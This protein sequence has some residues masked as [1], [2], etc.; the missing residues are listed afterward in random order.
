MVSPSQIISARESSVGGA[1]PN[2]DEIHRLT[3]SFLHFF[4]FNSLADL[5]PLVP[6][7]SIWSSMNWAKIMEGVTTGVTAAT[8]LALFALMRYRVGDLIFRWRLRHDLKNSALA[9][10]DTA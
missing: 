1:S 10:I 2:F 7:R 4:F 8:V 6:A 9:G 5:A 3:P